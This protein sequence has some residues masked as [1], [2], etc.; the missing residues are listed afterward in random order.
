[1]DETEVRLADLVASNPSLPRR[2]EAPVS[3]LRAQLVAMVGDG[4]ADGAAAIA[5]EAHLSEVER[6]MR[7]IAR[8]RPRG[9][10]LHTIRRLS[11]P[12]PG[13]MSPAGALITR[14]VLLA[15]VMKYGS[16]EDDS[17][18]SSEL[19]EDLGGCLRLREF[20]TE[21]ALDLLTMN[22]LAT[23][24]MRT[25]SDYRRLGKGAVLATVGGWVSTPAQQET[26]RLLQ[27]YDYR[28]RERGDLLSNFGAAASTSAVGVGD[29]FSTLTTPDLNVE[30]R[31]IPAELTQEH[32][33]VQVNSPTYLPA[34]WSIRPVR[35]LLRLFANEV[36][37][38]ARLDA[39]ELLG[40]VW[41]IAKRHEMLAANNF[42]FCVQ[43]VQRGY[44][45]SPRGR[46]LEGAIRHIAQ[47][48]QRYVEGTERRTISANAALGVVRRALAEMS[49]RADEFDNLVVRYQ[50]PL[51][52]MF[53]TVECVYFD[54]VAIPAYLQGVFQ[55][56]GALTGTRGNE[57]GIRFHRDVI[58]ATN[59]RPGVV[60]WICDRV[61]QT[62]G[63][64]RDLDASFVAGN[65]LYLLEC[66]ARVAGP[67]IY[68]GEYAAV[69][70]R[71]E[72]VQADLRKIEDLRWSL[73]RNPVGPNYKVPTGVTKVEHCVCAPQPEWIPSTD[74]AY[75][76]SP[77]TPRVC[78]VEE[79]FDHATAP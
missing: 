29:V 33:R 46:P 51:K 49:Y 35:N 66:K 19:F 15:A 25:A 73:E 4:L 3:D 48:Y 67:R 39:D 32:D 7:Q 6:L 53:T 78:T 52:P 23:E 16:G 60:P 70:A 12:A 58:A 43:Y 75:W 8:R 76:L 64:R 69:K 57:K 1:M 17:G 5:L 2:A 11:P 65:T 77:T 50:M 28:L 68:T 45:P 34:R 63:K 41:A 9:Y 20:T 62:P 79:V 13:A 10:W 72:L 21:H 31:P 55:V 30:A 61:L 56:V 27:L 74:P 22:A 18:D 47:G 26:E 36:R 40:V 14:N 37:E 54:L 44:F 24:Y 59:T 42:D 71:W 38:A